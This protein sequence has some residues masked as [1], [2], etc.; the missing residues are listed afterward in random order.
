[1]QKILYRLSVVSLVCTILVM[2]AGSIVRMTGSGMGCP[3]WPKCFGYVIPPT[4]VEMLT[5]SPLRSF[6]KGNIIIVDE[7]LLV[8][9]DG[10]TATESFDKSKW[11]PYTKHDYAIFNPFHTWVEFINRLIGAFTGLPVLVLALL[12][13]KMFKKDALIP[14]LAWLGLFLLGYEAWLGKKVVDGNLIPHQITYHMFGA[15]GLVAVFTFLIVRL[16]SVNLDFHT[17]RNRTTI[18]IGAVGIALLLIQI[19][20]GTTVREEVDTIG[21]NN[22]ITA[23][24]WIE[25]LSVIFKFHRT[26]SLIVIGVLGWF[27]VRLIEAHTISSG[28]RLLIGFLIGEVLVGMGLAYLE[29]PAALQPIHLIF[30]VFNFA[31]ALFLLLYYHKKTSN[32]TVV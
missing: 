28:P 13:L 20:L 29:M 26:Y 3:D 25:N 22:L 14:V 1:M 21:K 24:D 18:L 10:F 2:L 27:A 17:R 5:W 23:P 7:T 15:L 11:E 32:A 6:D 31:L 4:D 30:A 12:S 9:I 16:K 8:A 19:F